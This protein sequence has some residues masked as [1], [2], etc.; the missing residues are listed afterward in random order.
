MSPPRVFDRP[1]IAA[2]LARRPAGPPDFVTTLALDD[3]GERLLATHR[4]FERALLVAPDPRGLPETAA[5]GGG[6][7]RFALASTL[8]P[9]EGVPLVA[10][11]PLVL[12]ESGYD[13]IVSLF[14]LQIID[15]VPGFLARI[16][17]HLAPDGL[18]LGVALG[19]DSLRELRAAFLAADAETSGGA[20]ARVAPMIP[21]EVVPGLLQR[22]GFALPVADI[23][24]HVVRYAD[25][26]ALLRELR[27]LGAPNPLADRPD[28]PMTREVLAAALASYAGMSADTDG[29]IRATLELI[30]LSGWAPHE[31]QQKPL[32][33]G[34]AKVSLASVL[35]RTTGGGDT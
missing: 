5:S 31:S 28:R 13:L 25:P 8:V 2:R 21:F 35:G 16:H 17:A 15:D 24:S 27:T 23:E 34:S 29:R 33:P 10:T 3:L 26:L 12:P 6:P 30:W 4:R 32:K 22:A 19:G 9:V 7:I 14:D 18:F 11:D 20:F 1:L